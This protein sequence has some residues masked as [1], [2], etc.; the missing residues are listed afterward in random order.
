MPYG[1][2]SLHGISDAAVM[3]NYVYGQILSHALATA[4]VLISLAR[5]LLQLATYHVEQQHSSLPEK[6]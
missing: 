3:T 4:C 2:G 5:A 1:R 6:V